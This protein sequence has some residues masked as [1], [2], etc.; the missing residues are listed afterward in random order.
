[1]SGSYDR[2]G[3]R[4]AES[5]ND[6]SG[7]YQ[8]MFPWYSSLATGKNASQASAHVGG[9]QRRSARP[10][11]Y[12]GRVTRTIASRSDRRDAILGGGVAGLVLAWRLAQAGRSVVLTPRNLAAH[13]F[14]NDDAP[15]SQIRPDDW[16]VPIVPPY[17]AARFPYL[18]GSARAESCSV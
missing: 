7:K 4:P 15:L 11:D 5:G 18:T 14:L 8:V 1:M 16:A 2:P 10:A 3:G 9:V 17:Y 13:D 12:D 6:R